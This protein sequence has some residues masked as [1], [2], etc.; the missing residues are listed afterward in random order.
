[1]DECQYWSKIIDAIEA[2][3]FSKQQED[4]NFFYYNGENFIAAFERVVYFEIIGK[5]DYIESIELAMDNKQLIFVDTLIH[6]E[7]LCFAYPDYLFNTKKRIFKSSV[8]KIIY[9]NK[10]FINSFYR[11]KNILKKDETLSKHYNNI[12]ISI[13]HKFIRYLAP[14]YLELDS[15]VFI[16]CD[17]IERSVEL[18][19][20][21]DYNYVLM[22][23]K[24]SLSNLP[25]KSITTLAIL[26]ERACATLYL[27]NPTLIVVP[28]GN[29]PIYEVFNLASKT[30]GKKV[31]CIQQGW[32]PIYHNGF[33]NMHYDLFLSW[34]DEFSNLLQQYNPNQKFVAVGNYVLNS[35]AANQRGDSIS[36]FLQSVSVIIS[37]NIF[38]QLLIFAGWVAS[39]FPEQKII[40]REH[41]SKPLSREF[42]QTLL[43]YE[44]ISIMSP[45]THSL[46]DVLS[47]TKIA[48]SIYSTVLIEATQYG[49]IPFIFNPTAM[50]NYEPD[51]SKDGV[52]LE[53]KNIEDGKKI[54]TL[55]LRDNVLF[56]YYA[57]AMETKKG[58]YFKHIGDEA[59]KAAIEEIEGLYK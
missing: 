50:S 26:Y 48:I 41:P 25:S 30:L 19:T 38:Q 21:H 51:F 32:S 49:A 33:R 13:H 43:K 22:P 15:V 11:F 31:V 58:I 45:E 57:K 34:G 39:Q 28:E 6:K 24:G 55:L 23:N 7:I 27:T 18:C 44:N 16:I 9:S 12:F 52:G 35:C 4:P 20:E 1:M 40:L 3:T 47:L 2:Y 17:D 5:R 54:I 36:F 10:F 56:D 29:A 8:K 42:K 46:H 14:L 53:V 59:I 37:E